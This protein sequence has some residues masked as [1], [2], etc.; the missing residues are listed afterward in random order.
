[1][2]HYTDRQA[3]DRIIDANLN[4]VQE[5]VRVC[6]EF[7]RFILNNSALTKE[8]KHIRHRISALCLLPA[9]K[10]CIGKRD[11]ESDPGTTIHHPRELK[12]ARPSDILFAN[13]QRAKES[14]RVLEEF[15]KLKNKTAALQFKK[16][17]Y[18]L[19]VLEQKIRERIERI[20]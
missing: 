14:V 1:M 12:R 17:R 6:E 15:A 3:V 9:F 7:T 13:M 20:G 8:L 5:G 19:Y 2:R 11:T 4:R 18:R 10:G 16:L